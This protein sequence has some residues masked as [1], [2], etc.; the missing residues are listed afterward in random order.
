MSY[1]VLLADA[2]GTLFD[3]HAGEKNAISDAFSHFGIPV[4]QAYVRAYHQENDAQ[5]KRL[6]R[7]ETTQAALRV[8]RFRN[9]LAHAGLMGDAMEMSA[10]YEDCLARQRVM[11]PGAADFCRAVSAQMPI[12]LVTNG[13]AKVQRGRFTACELTPYISGLIIS[14]EIGHAKPHPAMVEKALDMAGIA[15]KREAVLMGDSV[16]ADIAA[17]NNADVDSILYTNGA[18]P[19][20]E[21]GATY[22][23]RTFRDA[24]SVILGASYCLLS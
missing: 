22:V 18:E 11:L 10:Y 12:Y 14:E 3:F 21:H 20:A 6:E 2:D 16:T 4:T 19:P 23:A 5:W 13:I 15:N 1:R 7:G 9:F 17:A 8:E 24:V